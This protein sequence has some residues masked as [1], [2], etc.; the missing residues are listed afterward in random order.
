[1]CVP[2]L[3][4]AGAL[5]SGA[6]SMAAASAQA[7]AANANAAYMERQAQIERDKARYEASRAEDRAKN[8]RGKQVAMAGASG[9]EAEG[10]IGEVLVDTM[11]QQNLDVQAIRYGGE[12]NATNFE[13]KAQI[14]RMNASNYKTAGMFNAASGAIG[15]YTKLQPQFTY[16]V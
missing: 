5:I 11:N 6:G 16:Q 2:M 10:A 3:G 7:G 4:L 1:M 9:L 13:Y 8:L 12:I 15:A 14:E